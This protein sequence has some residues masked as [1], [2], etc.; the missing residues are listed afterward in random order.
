M[1]VAERRQVDEK[2]K[3]I[4]EL[5]RKVEMIFPCMYSIDSQLS[6]VPLWPCS[7]LLLRC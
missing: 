7:G 1:V 3:K 6:H 2:V 5:K 4:I